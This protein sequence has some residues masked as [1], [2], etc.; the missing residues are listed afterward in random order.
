MIFKTRYSP[1]EPRKYAFTTVGDSATQ[2][3]FKDECDVNNI[4]AKYKKTNMLTHINRHQGNFG[5]WSNVEDYQTSL[6]KIIRARD[7]FESLPSELRSKFLNDPKNLIE[8]INDDKN[9]DE[10]IKLGLKVKREQ[11]ESIQ[12]QFEKALA[13]NDEK[14][15]KSVKKD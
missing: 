7:A 10:A 2:Q 15:Q 1:H 3:Q 4:L 14:R 13:S 5:D 9:N 11:P 6:N 12:T 8:F